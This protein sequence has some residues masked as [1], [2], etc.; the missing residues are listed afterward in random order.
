MTTITAKTIIDKASIQLLDTGNTRWTRA[1]LLSWINDAQRQIVIMSPNATNKISVVKLNAGTRQAIPSDGWTLLEVV[2]YMGT[3]GTKPGRAIRLASREQI[4]SFNPD[5]HSDTPAA[6]PKHYIFDLQD[7]TAFFVYPPNT[8]TGYI[9]INYSPDPSDLVS[10]SETIK[11]NNIFETV[12]LD[13]VLYRACSKDAEYAPGIQLAAGY[14]S[15]FM[16]AMGQK[17]QSEAEN[18]PNQQ[19]AAKDPS[20]PGTQS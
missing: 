15:T 6:M 14:L 4:D 20:K 9:E 1:E 2:R 8:G 19:F 13:Y 16:S 10:E 3:T 18:S 17:S 5:W 7:Q 11:L 12:I